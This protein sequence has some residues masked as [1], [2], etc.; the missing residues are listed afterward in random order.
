[1]KYQIIQAWD[2]PI[3]KKHTYIRQGEISFLDFIKLKIFKDHSV[4]EKIFDKEQND[5]TSK[6][7]PSMT[8]GDFIIIGNSIYYC[9]SVSFEKIKG[10]GSLKF[11]LKEKSE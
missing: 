8:S 6:H 3:I 7:T 9:D 1:M 5:H 2:R 10:S 4:L 11:L